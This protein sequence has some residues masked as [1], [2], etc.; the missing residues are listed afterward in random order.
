MKLRLFSSVAV[1]L[2]LFLAF[3]AV[4]P[5]HAQLPS[6]F[7][8]AK[9]VPT[10]SSVGTTQFT[11]T[12]I[13]SSG[14][15]VIMSTS[16]ANGYAGVCV[17]NCGKTGT[18]WIAFAGLVPVTVDGTASIQHYITISSTTGGDGHDTGAATY[19]TSGAVIGRVQ[20][21]AT[22]GNPAMVDL[23][24]AETIAASGSSGPPN[25][26]N[27]VTP[28][29]YTN[30]TAETTLETTSA[31]AAGEWATTGRAMYVTASGYCTN[32][33]GAGVTAK[34]NLYMDAIALDSNIYAAW[35][36]VPTGGTGGWTIR[37]EVQVLTTGSSGTWQ[38][39]SRV[40]TVSNSGYV[41]ATAG[42]SQS[43]D[44]TASHTFKVTTTLGT[45]VA[46]A[47]CTVTYMNVDRSIH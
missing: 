31:I 34:I 16:D 33:S 27:S 29:S 17:S 45:A 41:D 23:F 47:G 14:N 20:S 10:D 38:G 42:A 26:Y 8:Y 37:G 28:N 22:S 15:A 25:E 5:A 6:A 24:D 44:T 46:T 39:N 7:P 13:N 21:G 11:L 30:S 9:P 19:P 12:K 35:W 4:I 3:L 32:T 2:F 40:Q 1:Y 43:I 18:A 36:T